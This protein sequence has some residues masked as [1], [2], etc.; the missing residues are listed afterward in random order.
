MDRFLVK[1]MYLKFIDCE[2]RYTIL[3]HIIL[4]M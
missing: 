3:I 1:M 4:R 2:S